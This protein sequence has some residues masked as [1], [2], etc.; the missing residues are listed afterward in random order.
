MSL[1]LP[2]LGAEPLSVRPIPPS[3]CSRACPA[4]INVKAYV[5]LIAEGR[6][7]EALEVVRRDCPLPGICGRVCHHPCE[8]VCLRGEID[9][10]VAIRSLKRF[11]AD[12]ALEVP[13]PAGAGG[14]TA[15][16]A[17]HREHR[18]A[19]VGAGPAGL[20]A[21]YDLRMAGYPVTVFEA[22]PEPGGMLRY[23]IAPYRLPREVLAAE[24]EALCGPGLEIRCGCRIGVDLGLDELL[25][26]GYTAGLFAVGAQRGRPLGIPGERDCAGVEDALTF[27]RRVNEGDRTPCAGRVLV[28]G[29]GLT[30]I[31][32]ARSARRLGADSVEILYRRTRQEMP[33]GE[34]ELEEARSEGIGIRFL[35]SPKRVIA[36]SGRVEALECVENALGEPDSSGRR[37]PVPLPG[38]QFTIRA[39]RVLGAVGQALDLDFLPDE[40]ASRMTERGRLSAE[41]GSAMTPM[42]GVFAAGDA[43]TGPA[44]VIE[45]V[46]AG[47]RAAASIRDF[48]DPERGPGPDSPAAV[49]AVE[50]GLPDARPATAARRPPPRAPLSEGREFSEVELPYRARDAMAE[51]GRCLRCGP[52]SECAVCVPSCGRRHV[53]LAMRE[54]GER[55][56]PPIWV[57]APVRIAT[58]PPA[59]ASLVSTMGSTGGPDLAVELAPALASIDEALCRGCPRCVEVCPFEAVGFIDDRDPDSRVRIDPARCRGC[60][61]CA[62]ACPTGA[63]IPGFLPA[64]WWGEA[65]GPTDETVV[66]ACDPRAAGVEAALR[67][68]GVGGR[69]VRLRC[70]GQVDAGLLLDLCR[71]G[72]RRVLVAACAEN[73]CRFERGAALAAQQ[74]AIARS[75]LASFGAD[76]ESVVI[77]APGDPAPGS[78]PG[79]RPGESTTRP[80]RAAAAAGGP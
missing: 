3:P 64:E 75:L 67:R 14:A 29:G 19:V 13:A 16:P 71:R 70:V 25:Q 63:A 39:D 30:A 43:V 34:A 66:L 59:A 73:G 36:R 72:A 42:L 80:D 7:G 28:I 8:E 45:A 15:P 37:R 53:R 26:E 57:R 65:A 17:P 46:A 1:L 4:G 9:E 62:A 61:L 60:N 79:Q 69:L 27:L 33:A 48:L 77:D 74:V 51:A 44:T 78:L 41:P 35:V 22:A 6:F 2:S 5:S 58:G 50:Y 38:S 52:C 12:L 54:D 47:H 20:T 10:P 55:A 32:A 11:V 21:A 76:A 40:R 49:S 68:S 23:G 24:I 18:V 56:G 31:E